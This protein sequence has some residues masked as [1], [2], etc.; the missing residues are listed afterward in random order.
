MKTILALT[1]FSPFSINAVHYAADLAR[2]IHAQ[3]I[4]FNAV[5]FPVSSRELAVSGTFMEDILESG[6]KELDDLVENI[7]SRTKG[8]I[9][10]TSERILG[11]VESHIRNMSVR[12]K[13]LAIIM[14]ITP[15]KSFDRALMGS[16]I[17]YTINHA[18]FPVLIIPY[19][20]VYKPIK[21]IGLACDLEDIEKYT[22]FELLKEWLSL[23]NA[24]LNIIYVTVNNEGFKSDQVSESITLQ[25]HLKSFNPKFNFIDGN[26]LYEELNAFSKTNQLDLLIVIPKGHG[27]SNALQY[28]RSRKVITHNQIPVLALHKFNSAVNK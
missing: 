6:N 12:I 1:D 2:D 3:L 17:F 19:N 4:I 23:F 28:S 18:P 15:G 26:N 27:I 11:S 9:F 21:E 24:N 22:P 16:A 25:N 8:Q 5:Q 20:T 14:G 7:K 10:V 13:P